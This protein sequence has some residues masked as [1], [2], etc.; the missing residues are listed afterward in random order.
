MEITNK[1]FDCTKCP[2]CDARNNIVTGKGN[3]PSKY[4]VIG[5]APSRPGELLKE[6]FT[7]L[8]GNILDEILIRAGIDLEDCYFVTSLLCRPTDKKRGNNRMPKDEELISCASNVMGIYD[9][10]DPELVIL[11]GKVSQEFYGKVFNGHCKILAPEFIV[12]NGGIGS[13]YFA[14]MVL[15]LKNFL[16][17]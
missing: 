16:T 1:K 2:L 11:V 9:K 17:E 10:C 12:K 7:G 4:L 6:P 8:A 3:L 14:N 5:E 15:R 13:F